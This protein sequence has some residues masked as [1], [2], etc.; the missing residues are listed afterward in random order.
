[1][2]LT[3]PNQE[4]RRDLKA[5]AAIL[6]DA[7]QDL[8]RQ[9]KTY[10][11]PEFLAAMEKIGRLQECVDKLDGYAEEVKNGAVRRDKPE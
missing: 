3:K 8:F 7:A 1:M 9:A 11:E 2:S 4:L 5:A 6:D 10:A